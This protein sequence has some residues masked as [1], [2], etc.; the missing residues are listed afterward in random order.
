MNDDKNTTTL[1][2]LAA[3]YIALTES[4]TATFGKSVEPLSNRLIK[5]MLPL[6]T[7]GAADLCG[8]LIAFTSTKPSKRERVTTLTDASVLH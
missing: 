6:M 3:I 4:I 5:D 7:P 1:Y 2:A 8:Q